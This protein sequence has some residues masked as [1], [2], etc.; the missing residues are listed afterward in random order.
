MS[1]RRHDPSPDHGLGAL[2][3]CQLCMHPPMCALW[4]VVP[5]IMAW[6]PAPNRELSLRDSTIKLSLIAMIFELSE[7]L[8]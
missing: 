8:I 7:A 1:T 6:T 5:Q 4:A 3:I 2:H